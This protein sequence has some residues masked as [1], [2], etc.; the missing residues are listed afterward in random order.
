MRV[1][2]LK[3]VLQEV[4]GARSARSRSPCLKEGGVWSHTG[5]T[6]GSRE[7]APPCPLHPSTS[8]T[9][10]WAFQRG[11]LG[12]GS[13]LST[14]SPTLGDWHKPRW[15]VRMVLQA[16][17]YCG[18]GGGQLV[19]AGLVASGT[20][21]KAK[22]SLSAGVKNQEPPHKLGGHGRPP[23]TATSCHQ[24]GV[25]VQCRA[26][27]AARLL[28]AYLPRQESSERHGSSLNSPWQGL[29]RAK[30]T[31][32]IPLLPFPKLMARSCCRE[33]VWPGMGM[34]QD[35]EI[36][37]MGI[38]EGEPWSKDPGEVSP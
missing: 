9:S 34:G 31:S 23:A 28:S 32:A 12:L 2:F 8:T 5:V 15:T 18:R 26:V 14:I 13:K 22:F 10:P 17:G 21:K 11:D 4:C 20:A 3:R 27:A 35:L 29:A 33:V 16:G 6:G 30:N 24:W 7:A 25:P 37:F 36:I 19:P 38:P 1:C